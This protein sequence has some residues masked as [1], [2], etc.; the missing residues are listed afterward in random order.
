MQQ[1]HPD[2]CFTCHLCNQILYSSTKY[3]SHYAKQHEGEVP[4][5]LANGNG[6]SATFGEFQCRFCSKDYNNK[7][8]LKAHMRTKHLNSR[9]FSCQVCPKKFTSSSNLKTHTRIV[10]LMERPYECDE[11]DKSYASEGGLS[12]HQVK[13]PKSSK[14]FQTFFIFIPSSKQLHPLYSLTQSF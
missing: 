9:T 12:A 6:N 4:P 5:P 11:C 13:E 8:S 7:N 1:C 10:H 2:T 3:N 14:I